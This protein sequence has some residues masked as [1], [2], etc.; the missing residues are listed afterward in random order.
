MGLV[1][2][3]GSKSTQSYSLII[4]NRALNLGSIFRSHLEFRCSDYLQVASF[5]LLH[6]KGGLERPRRERARFAVGTPIRNMNEIKRGRLL[7]NAR[8]IPMQSGERRDGSRGPKLVPGEARP[9]RMNPR[10][11]PTAGVEM[12]VGIGQP[13]RSQRWHKAERFLELILLSKKVIR[14]RKVIS[15]DIRCEWANCTGR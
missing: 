8:H 2:S 7:R 5:I 3:R 6:S 13:E 10:A 15:A 12:G 14:R 9:L 11:P 4:S 1:Y